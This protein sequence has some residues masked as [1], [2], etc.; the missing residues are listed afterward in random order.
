MVRASPDNRSGPRESG[1]EPGGDPRGDRLPEHGAEPEEKVDR[2][3]ATSGRTDEHGLTEQDIAESLLDQIREALGDMAG[4]LQATSRE[5]QRTGS[6]H[7]PGRDGEFTSARTHDGPSKRAFRQGVTESPW[8]WLLAAA[9]AGYTLAWMIYAGNGRPVRVQEPD[10]AK[11]R[12]N[13]RSVA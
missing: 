8:P 5:E 13:R 6:L 10:G 1:F 11:R 7:D 9:A 3:I 4:D 2:R 12:R